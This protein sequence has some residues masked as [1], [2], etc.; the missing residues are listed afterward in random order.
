M[1]II[2]FFLIILFFKILF[3]K[4][5]FFFNIHKTPINYLQTSYQFFILLLRLI[6]KVFVF[7]RLI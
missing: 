3:R 6:R 5:K 4:I 2:I 7:L 1:V